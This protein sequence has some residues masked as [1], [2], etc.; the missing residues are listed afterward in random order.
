M[1]FLFE[2]IEKEIEI[3]MGMSNLGLFR[4]KMDIVVSNR[5]EKTETV[6]PT[7]TGTINLGNI[8]QLSH[9]KILYFDRKKKKIME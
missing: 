3:S 6:F 8:N 5:L 7:Q 4:K 1:V 2:N 9:G